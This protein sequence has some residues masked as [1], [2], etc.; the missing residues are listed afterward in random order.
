MKFDPAGATIDEHRIDGTSAD[1]GRLYDGLMRNPDGT[2]TGIE[3]KS[4]SASRNAAQRGFDDVVSHDR[5]AVATLNGETIRIVE[6][7]LEHVR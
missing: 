3:V 6:I 4:G 5:P 7:V 2:D 1:Q